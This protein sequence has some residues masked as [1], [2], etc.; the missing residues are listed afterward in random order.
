VVVEAMHFE[1]TA[2]LR[3]AITMSSLRLRGDR[4]LRPRA[5]TRSASRRLRRRYARH[6]SPFKAGR[7][8]CG[9]VTPA[10]PSHSDASVR[11]AHPLAG[12]PG[13]R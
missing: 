8:F 2:H 4:P 6:R 3:A 12:R 13:N 1:R 11:P 9:H 10:P 5:P 7:S